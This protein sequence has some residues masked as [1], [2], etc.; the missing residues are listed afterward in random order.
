MIKTETKA[1]QNITKQLKLDLKFFKSEVQTMEQLKTSLS[2]WYYRKK[3]TN[4]I[5]E[6][7]NSNKYNLKQ[8]K[9]VINKR[10]IKF[11]DNKLIKV[12]ANIENVKKVDKSAC[13][14]GQC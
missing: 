9:E 14:W 4:T 1:K 5:I 8:A 10:L 13:R 2:G 3:M 12:L 7:I 6:N 11:Y